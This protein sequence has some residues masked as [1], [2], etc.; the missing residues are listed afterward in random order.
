MEAESS[1]LMYGKIFE[2]DWCN[3]KVYHYVVKRD[4][5]FKYMRG[6]GL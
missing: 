4:G 1:V 6:K 3:S 5:D 2:W